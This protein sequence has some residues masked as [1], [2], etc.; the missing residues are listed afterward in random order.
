[1]SASLNGRGVLVT[2]PAHQAAPL[3]ELI[4][5]AAGKPV[6]FPVLEILDADDLQPLYALIDQLDSVDM[7]IFIS[8]NAVNKAMNLIKS[9]REL[10]ATLKIAAIG[11]GSSKELKHFGITDIIAP[12]ARF[13]SENLLEMSQLQDVAG[14]RIVIFRGD[15]GREV[16]GDTLAARGARIEYAECYRRS[17]P[18]AS[19]GGLLRQWSR[20]EIN[21]VTVTSAEGLRNLYDMLGKLGRQWLKTTPVFVPHPRILEVA[22]ELGL[23]CA[24]ATPVGDEGLVQGMIEWFRVHP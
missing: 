3:A 19:A 9:R 1:M 10:P 5:A 13:D 18:N 7:A 23:E 14:Q 17:R 21:A 6:L 8:P 4:V 24:V 15:G 20:N 11:R 2:R 22:R 16:L 12:T